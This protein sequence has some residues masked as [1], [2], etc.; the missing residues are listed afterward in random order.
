MEIL[1]TGEQCIVQYMPCDGSVIE[2]EKKK[3]TQDNDRKSHPL[4]D[5]AIAYLMGG[6]VLYCILYCTVRATGQS[7]NQKSGRTGALKRLE[8]YMHGMSH[9]V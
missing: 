7:R 3:W 4:S 2:G 9:G 5:I 1:G 8:A 6:T